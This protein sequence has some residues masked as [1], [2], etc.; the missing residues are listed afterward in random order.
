MNLCNFKNIRGY[1]GRYMISE[2]GEIYSK[3]SKKIL[4]TCL[5]KVNYHMITLC[6]RY[7]KEK[8]YVHRL[9]AIAFI[10][11]PENKATVNHKNG[12]KTDNRLANLEWNT[13]SE[14]NQHAL[15]NKL[16]IPQ[17]GRKLTEGQVRSIRIYLKQ[18]V[19]PVIIGKRYKVHDRT[20]RDIRNGRTWKHIGE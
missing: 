6:G 17:C 14:N 7:K 18:G 20:I 5:T 13:Y 16:R 1:E 4:K 15:D 12:V 9:L 2:K 19:S 10:P 3:I 8:L 11:N